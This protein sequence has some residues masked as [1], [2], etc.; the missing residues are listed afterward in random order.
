MLCQLLAASV[1]PKSAYRAPHDRQRQDANLGGEPMVAGLAPV[2]G[3][4]TRGIV[5]L[6]ATQQTKHLAPLLPNQR[7]GVTDAQMTRL[8][9]PATAPQDG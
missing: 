5:L 8:N 4:Q 1:G 2:L 7:T 3:N 9:E 6:E